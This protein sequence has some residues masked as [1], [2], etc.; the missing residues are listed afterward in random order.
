MKK[1]NIKNIQPIILNDL[2]RFGRDYDGGYVL[3]KQQ[4]EK[5]EHLLSFGINNDWSF[6]EDFLKAKTVEL[7]AFDYSVYDRNMIRDFIGSILG[8]IFVLRRS[9]V[10]ENWRKLKSFLD[11]QKNI[12]RYFKK[13]RKRYF[14]PKFVGIEDDTMHISFETIF[15]RLTNPPKLS[16]FVKM[17]IEGDEYK[18]LPRMVPFFDKIN[19]MIIEFH[20]L[21]HPEGFEKILTQLTSNFHIGHIHANNCFEIC[22][23]SGLPKVLE[24]TL[25]NKN[26][27]S[28]TELSNKKYPIEGLDF[29]NRKA[30]E[31]I[32]FDFQ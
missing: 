7:Y 22:Y 21:N 5:T 9:K 30:K 8:S 16:V 28:N 13:N 20:G 18:I 1:Y 23:E 26:L 32:E 29:P 10:K 19:G 27:V 15:E 25:I 12:K 11:N 14:I 4:I 3:S 2:V 24:I 17:D 31:D 6:E